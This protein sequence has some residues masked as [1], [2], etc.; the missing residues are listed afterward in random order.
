MQ[1]YANAPLLLYV[2]FYGYNTGVLE[3]MD[4]LSPASRGY[5][6]RV[7]MWIGCT[8]RLLHLHSA[9]R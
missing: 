8:K 1:C 3:S 9:L 5:G 7:R 4:G 6:R 2:M